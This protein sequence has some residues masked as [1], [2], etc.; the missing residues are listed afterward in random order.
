MIAT[1]GL[2]TL[3]IGDILRES[4][5]SNGTFYARFGGR[6]GLIREVQDRLL[7]RVEARVMADCAA[8][9]DPA[10]PLDKAVA[11]LVGSLLGVFR[12]NA[13]L[14]CGFMRRGAVDPVLQ[15]R[16]GRTRGRVQRL[17][18][19]ALTPRM[20]LGAHPDAG[21]VIAMAYGVLSSVLIERVSADESVPVEQRLP[22]EVL[23][24]ELDRLLLAYLTGPHTTAKQNSSSYS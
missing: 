10:V 2:E 11:V 24:E 15:E 7:A 13:G 16:A 6:D 1:N 8:L 5:V 20:P 19:D 4:Q 3:K 14:L 23:S 9:A 17:F 21:R 12:D 22:W 18:T